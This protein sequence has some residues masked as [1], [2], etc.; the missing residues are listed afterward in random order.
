MKAKH[1]RTM[2]EIRD[3]LKI[4]K[5]RRDIS[6]AE[7]ES[8]KMEMEESLRP[9]KI[10]AYAVNILKRYGTLFLLRKLLK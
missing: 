6:L 9:L 4:L 7:L 8:S 10:L 5:L 3:E 1:Y 2:Q